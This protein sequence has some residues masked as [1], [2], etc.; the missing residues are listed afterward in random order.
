MYDSI[1]N[2]PMRQKPNNKQ[3]KDT[4]MSTSDFKWACDKSNIINKLSW[5]A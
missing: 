3:N 1:M 5:L 2:T 4:Q